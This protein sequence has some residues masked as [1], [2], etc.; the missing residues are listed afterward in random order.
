MALNLTL[1]E[2]NR[3]LTCEENTL[4]HRE[5]P[6]P[7]RKPQS[8]MGKNYDSVFRLYGSQKADEWRAQITRMRDKC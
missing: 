5:V 1:D 2:K 8:E 7:A 4:L 3:G 6:V